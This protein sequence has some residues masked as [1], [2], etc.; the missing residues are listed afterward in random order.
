MM[1]GL[2]AILILLLCVMVIQKF[3]LIDY[4]GASKHR[5]I[6][7]IFFVLPASFVYE[8]YLNIRN[9]VKS[10]RL[11]RLMNHEQKVNEVIKQILS[12]KNDGKMFCT[13]RSPYASMSVY[14]AAYKKEMIN[15]DLSSFIDILEINEEDQTITVEPLVTC[16]QIT[17]FLLDLG[18]TL[19]VVPELD[20]LTIG[21][22]VNGFGI[23][24]SSHKYG[25]F[26]ST[27]NEFEIILPNGDIKI[28][29]KKLN[30]DIFRVIPWSYGT[31]GFL[32]SVKI[33]IIPAKKFCCLMYIPYHDQ[34]T[35]L[36]KF[37]E[38]SNDTRHDF[39]EGILYGPN[40]GV[41][42]LGKQTDNIQRGY[43]HELGRFWSPWFYKHIEKEYL[44]GYYLTQF[45]TSG[46]ENIPLRAYYHRHTKSLFWEMETII[47][48][49]NNVFFRFL[50]GW[51]C[52]P[53]ISFLKF[54]TTKKLD[55]LNKEYHVIEDYLVPIDKL[56]EITNI[57]NEDIGVYPIWLCPCKIEPTD[58]LLNTGSSRNEL[59]VDVGIYGIPKDLEKFQHEEFHNKFESYLRSI[60]GFQALYAQTYQTEE[61]F[62]KMFDHTLYDKVRQ[63]FGCGQ[64][65]PS[66]FEK[67]CRKN[68]M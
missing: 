32:L 52:P 45:G 60:K 31:V 20:D 39:V 17:K 24:T 25:L 35:F 18:W 33:K 34:K 14:L 6:L 62:R 58:G 43:I 26:Q 67:V 49:G 16:G 66:V 41:L 1:S 42:I 57:Q 15:I 40:K 23:E 28:C 12:C 55:K 56:E 68:R 50:F 64:F 54:T 13:N 10:H 61:E 8:T 29:S 22:L 37:R 36:E 53:K 44:N 63:E 4:I 51:V 65:L 11:G 59:Y 19:E 46:Y 30:E 21:G 7:V 47:P 2:Y 38:A 27:C 3:G 9:K 48:F 5:W